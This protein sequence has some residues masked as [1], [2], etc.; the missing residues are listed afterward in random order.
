MM[1]KVSGTVLQ[2]FFEAQIQRREDIEAIEAEA[3]AEHQDLLEHA[4]ARH[5]NAS[6]EALADALGDGRPASVP[7]PRPAPAPS[8][9]RF[10]RN[11]SR[12]PAAAAR[13]SRSATA[14]RWKKKTTTSRPG[15]SGRSLIARLPADPRCQDSDTGKPGPTAGLAGFA[16]VLGCNGSGHEPERRAR[17]PER[18]AAAHV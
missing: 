12:A 13:S 14:P 16:L 2:R 11:E 8:T 18:V 9:P 6:P 17:A 15:L 4:V 1:A 3:A 5:V 7:P 10:S